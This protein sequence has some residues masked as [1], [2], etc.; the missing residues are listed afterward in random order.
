V[1]F[2]GTFASSR[3]LSTLLAASVFIAAGCSQLTRYPYLTDATTT[4]ATINFAT[5]L[6]SPA[7]VV[8]Y[9]RPSDG[10]AG[11]SAVATVTPITVGSTAEYQHRA[12]LNGLSAG[13]SYC[14]RMSQ[15][16]DDLLG[17]D[18]SPTFV[19]PPATGSSA[20]FSFAV[21]GDWGAGTSDESNVLARIASSPAKFV[22]TVGDNVYNSGTQTDYG[23]LSE[24]N[25]FAPSYWKPVGTTKPAY[26]A[27]GN[28][29]FTQNLPYL[30]NWPEPTVSQAS[31]G[32]LQQDS[33]C[34]I[35]TMAASH[36]YASAWYA[37]DWGSAR[38]YV[39][40][41]AWSDS[42]GG[43]QGDFDAHWNGPVSGCAVCG[44]ELQWL[45][46]DLAAH[47]GTSMKFAFFHYP[48][49]SDS[50]SQP[51]DTYLDGASA[52]EGVLAHNGVRIVFNGHAHI[53]ERNL[54]QIAGTP[55][56]SYVTGGGGDELGSVHCSSFDAYAV[57]SSSA[58]HAPVPTSKSQVFHYLLVTVNGKQVT[59]TPVNENGNTF[60]IKTY[61]FP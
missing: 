50:S 38:F 26:L 36:T 15:S 21:L 44:T 22:M 51:S 48:L 39:L 11:R 32:R 24:G 41:A 3:R 53:Y 17:N 40:E 25:V 10:C 52:L 7:P 49:H 1:S 28:H 12:V 9:G 58:C 45:Q 30:Q 34:C 43:Y 20:S 19:A 46:S 33:Y 14:Y 57:G 29:G 55:M 37:F 23:D 42:H 16:D 18:T 13:M 5:N 8:A 47:T 56:V 60:D 35:P 31:H 59:V 27:Q 61:S 54:P 2:P 6:A 4:S